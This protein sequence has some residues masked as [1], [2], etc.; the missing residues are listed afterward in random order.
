MTGHP[1]PPLETRLLVVDHLRAES[2]ALL[3]GCTMT[4]SAFQPQLKQSCNPITGSQHISSSGISRARSSKFYVTLHEKKQRIFLL[5]AIQSWNLSL[6]VSHSLILETTRPCS[7]ALIRQGVI[8]HRE[9]SGAGGAAPARR[10]A[11]PPATRWHQSAALPRAARAARP[12]PRPAPRPGRRRAL[13]PGRARCARC[14]GADRARGSAAAER[15]PSLRGGRGTQL[16]GEAPSVRPRCGPVG[17][18]WAATAMTCQRGTS[19]SLKEAK[20]RLKGVGAEV[21][22]TAPS[23]KC[24]WSIYQC[25][26]SGVSVCRVSLAP[27]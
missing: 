8:K 10:P 7:A 6:R 11:P 26:S 3:W 23:V 13:Q 4:P 25:H 5:S 18:V 19:R 22:L 9:W 21:Y 24:E 15:F 16:R 2:G 17:Q 12:A 20:S 14:K 1:K 27:F